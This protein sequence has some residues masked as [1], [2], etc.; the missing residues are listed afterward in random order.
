MANSDQDDGRTYTVLINHEEQYSLWLKCNDIPLGWKA[1]GKDGSKA[2]CLEYVKNV[3]TDMTP[4]SLR[5][6]AGAG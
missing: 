5:K 1:V 2:E 6:Q 4:L 3:W